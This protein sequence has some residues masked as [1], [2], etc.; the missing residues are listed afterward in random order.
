MS[1]EIS[2]IE[3]C[4]DEIYQLSFI[5]L[6]LVHGFMQ[7]LHSTA[8]NE[9]K[10]Q[11]TEMEILI[12]K[13]EPTIDKWN[14]ITKNPDMFDEAMKNL[15][16]Y[17]ETTWEI[18]SKEMRT[19][20][21]P[22]VTFTKQDPKKALNCLIFGFIGQ[23]IESKYNLLIPFYLKMICLQFYGNIIMNSNILNINQINT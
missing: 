19:K 20:Q 1:S 17:S 9:M 2:E 14:E 8:M 10:R 15:R 22:L 16:S 21:I 23:E 18:F 3:K 4:K 12:A 13:N 7:A 6:Q 11:K 5:S